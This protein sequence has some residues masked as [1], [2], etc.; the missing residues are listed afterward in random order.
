[1]NKPTFFYLT[2]FLTIISCN[3]QENSLPTAKPEKV[4]MSSERLNRIKPV[5]QRYVDEN[6]LPGLI[7]IVARQGKIVH[8]EKYGNMYIDKPMELDAIFSIA[9]MTKPITSVAIMMLYEEGYFQ[10]N[11]PVEKYIPEFK[12]LKVF[13][14]KD[15]LGIH[16]VDQIRPVS[17][18]DLLTHT[19]GFCYGDED[20][21]IDSMLNAA[22]VFDG[23][24]KDMILKLSK[25]PLLF[26]PG[27]EWNYSVSTDVLGYLVEVISGKPLD[28]FFKERIFKPLK[29][30]DTDFYVPIE[31]ANRIAAL[32]GPSDSTGIKV[33]VKTDTLKRILSPRKFL[34]GGA[35]LFSTA[36][37]YMIF[38]QMLLNKG[39]YNGVR[40]LGSKTVDYMTMNHLLDVLLPTKG[41]AVPEPGN[42]FGFGFAVVQDVAQLQIIGSVGSY[43]WTGSHGTFF[44]I[45]PSEQLVFLLMTHFSGGDF[46]DVNKFVVLTYQAIVD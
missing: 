11:D 36:K 26:Q 9:S 23:T 22:K 42:G 21:P 33:I 31:K 27:T 40:L 35:G 7:T 43:W 25:M 12:D 46:E 5:M 1:M 3:Q 39:E 44:D 6:K 8:F 10:L 17:I 2:I 34:S 18:R 37:D 14:H 19:S 13:S 15:K 41:Y 4:G 30:V 16:T 32:Y 45:D 20:T 29:M 38:S 24:L 28:I